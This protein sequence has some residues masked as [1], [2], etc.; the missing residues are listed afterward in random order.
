MK[1][2][3]FIPFACKTLTTGAASAAVSL[4][5]GAT[6]RVF[7]NST[8]PVFLR[9]GDSAVVATADDTGIPPN[10]VEFF[11]VVPNAQAQVPNPS[12]VVYIAA[13]SPGG[14]GSLNIAT[15]DGGA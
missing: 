3:A 9:F 4:D 13:I 14:A 5:V 6:V 2:D 1:I 8:F 10:G 7:N 11:S 12:A 15:G